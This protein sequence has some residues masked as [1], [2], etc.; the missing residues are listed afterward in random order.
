MLVRKRVSN[1]DARKTKNAI[2]ALHVNI[3]FQS[4]PKMFFS[5]A[6]I[7]PVEGEPVPGA[8]LPRAAA[9]STG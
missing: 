7:L 6:L 5:N 3:L 4:T 9:A 1:R 8:A 2:L